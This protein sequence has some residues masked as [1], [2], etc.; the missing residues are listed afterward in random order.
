MRS[1]GISASACGPGLA[2]NSGFADGS[3]F[4]A[5]RAATSMFGSSTAIFPRRPV[6]PEK[7][8]AD[9]QRLNR[10]AA[11]SPRL[12]APLFDRYPQNKAFAA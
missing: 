3:A 2:G 7:L 9:R 4:T 1:N 12:S 5:C 10:F 11:R 6:V 8:A